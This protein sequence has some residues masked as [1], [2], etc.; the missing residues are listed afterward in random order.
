MRAQVWGAAGAG[1]Y[2]CLPLCL[3]PC[4]S[5]HLVHMSDGTVFTSWHIALSMLIDSYT[6]GNMV[7]STVYFFFPSFLAGIAEY[8]LDFGF[9]SSKRWSRASRPKKL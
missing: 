1:L 6:T 9:S 8:F 4:L 5:L 2:I 7:P 3:V